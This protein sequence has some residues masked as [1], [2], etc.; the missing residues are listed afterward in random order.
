MSPAVN[1]VVIGLGNPDPEHTGTRHN[2]GW[3]AADA[4]ASELAAAW[5]NAPKLHASVARAG[6]TLI[7]K[8]TTYM[9]RSGQ[10]VRAALD[11]YKVP[12]SRLLVITDDI[13]LPFEELR[14]RGQGGAGG[15]KGLADIIAQLGNEEF[16]RLRV[17]VGAPPSP[18]A[19]PH[20]LG[21]FSQAEEAALPAVIDQAVIDAQEWLKTE[22]AD[23]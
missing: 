13:N 5:A 16:A 14:L 12:A 20:V 22:P 7:V 17:G 11:F 4:L 15:H 10:S 18:D 21:K 9:N 23:G 3:M 6:S 19:T 1:R 8:P 2:V